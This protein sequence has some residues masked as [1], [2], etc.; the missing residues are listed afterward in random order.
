MDK[1]TWVN[2]GSSY[3][4]SDMN[5]AYLYAQLELADEINNARLACWD[6]YYENL[7]PL[8]DAGYIEL[9]VIPEGCVHN[10]HMFYI[11]AVDLE[12]RTALIDYLKANGVYAVFHYIP[13][14]SAP[15]GLKYGRFHG[16]DKYTTKESERLL[17]LPMY[18]SLT[19]EQVDY[20][21]E[22]VKSFYESR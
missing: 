1:Y 9:P 4:P 21:C 14:H 3:L 6:R 12:V 5:A 17:R 16:E 20:I 15:A 19:L 13:L 7:K 18:Y 10:A 11:K 22:Q 8:A 2:Y